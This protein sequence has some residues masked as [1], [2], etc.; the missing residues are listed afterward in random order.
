MTNLQVLVLGF[1]T[2]QQFLSSACVFETVFIW[3]LPTQS[4]IR[5]I[6]ISNGV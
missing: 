2:P 4:C 3:K 6:P 5:T 1:Q